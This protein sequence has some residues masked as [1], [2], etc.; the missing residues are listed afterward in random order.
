MSAQ[1]KK[2]IVTKADIVNSGIKK[3][4]VSSQLESALLTSSSSS[5]FSPAPTQPTIIVESN[6]SA[7]PPDVLDT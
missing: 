6:Q 7:N 3:L 4:I 5:S 1:I 2:K